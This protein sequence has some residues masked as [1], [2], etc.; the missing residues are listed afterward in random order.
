MWIDFLFIEYKIEISI[1]AIYTHAR[2]HTHTH[3]R[4]EKYKFY[5]ENFNN[6]TGTVLF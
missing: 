5:I 2:A 3:I 6:C 1:Y 4:N